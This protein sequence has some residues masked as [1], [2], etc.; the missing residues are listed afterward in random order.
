MSLYPDLYNAFKQGGWGD[1]KR[2]LPDLT[3]SVE[4]FGPIGNFDYGI[5]TAAM[6]LPTEGAVFAGGAYVPSTWRFRQYFG[7]LWN[8]P[9]GLGNYPGDAVHIRHGAA[10]FDQ[11]TFGASPDLTP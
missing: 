9:T 3:D 1:R 10:H 11:G 2:P 4:A 7:N 6:G 5:G 8:E